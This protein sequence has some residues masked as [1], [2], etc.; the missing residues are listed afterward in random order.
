[1]RH[2]EHDFKNN[3]KWHTVSVHLVVK[4]PLDFIDVEVLMSAN[5]FQQTPH[6]HP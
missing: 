4:F 3:W 1:M 2:A 5:G 6:P